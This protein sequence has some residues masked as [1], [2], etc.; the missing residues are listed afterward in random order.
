MIGSQD[1]WLLQSLVPFDEGVGPVL[2]QAL[3]CDCMDP[4]V[5]NSVSPDINQDITAEFI[6][7][8]ETPFEDGENPIKKI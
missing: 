3:L 4:L 2:R 8:L 6:M 1:L 5:A 7:F